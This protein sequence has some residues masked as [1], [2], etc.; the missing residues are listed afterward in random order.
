[1]GCGYLGHLF[2]PA[3]MDDCRQPSR[4]YGSA[5]EGTLLSNAL[6]QGNLPRRT[7]RREN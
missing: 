2:Y 3:L 6:D 1:M 7:T 5:Q 4:L